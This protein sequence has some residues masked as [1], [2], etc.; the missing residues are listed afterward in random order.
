MFGLP[1]SGP[2]LGGVSGVSVFVFSSVVGSGEW[3]CSLHVKLDEVVL[4]RAV[5]ALLIALCC[6]F[7]KR[8]QSVS[9]LAA[10]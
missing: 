6:V 3:C 4:L 10:Q 9:F 5:L 7:E 1:F 2:T 8:G